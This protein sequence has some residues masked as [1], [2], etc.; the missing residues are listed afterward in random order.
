MKILYLSCLWSSGRITHDFNL[1]FQVK[2]LFLFEWLFSFEFVLIMRIC[3]YPTCP[4]TANDTKCTMHKFPTAREKCIL[5]LYA[6]GFQTTPSKLPA[7]YYLCSCH[8]SKGLNSFP[9]TFVDVSDWSMQ[10][11]YSLKYVKLVACNLC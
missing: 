2:S 5:W 3:K 1:W 9:D 7:A 8:F 4:H 11:C 6:C 10:D